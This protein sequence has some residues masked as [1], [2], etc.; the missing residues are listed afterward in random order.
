GP[1]WSSTTPT[2]PTRSPVRSRRRESCAAERSLWCSAPAAIATERSV[3]CSAPRAAD[4]I[5]LTSDN[6]RS[7]APEAIMAEIAAGIG[8]HRA[9]T[10][11]VD[12]ARAIRHALASAGEEDLIL[13]A[14]KG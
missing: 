14:G 13:I 4:R 10:R 11:E 1:T 5:V 12:R 6:P 8:R 2:R 9:L 7:E 3:P